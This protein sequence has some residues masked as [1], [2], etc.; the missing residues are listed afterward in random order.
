MTQG[1]KIVLDESPEI[2]VNHT[3]PLPTID[4]VHEHVHDGAFWS[5]ANNYGAT[6]STH[7]WHIRTANTTTQ[8]HLTAYVS[9]DTPGTVSLYK[10]PATHSITAAAT[11][12]NLAPVNHN[13]SDTTHTTTLQVFGGTAYDSSLTSTN[14]LESAY[15]GASVNP[16]FTFGGNAAS[17][18]EWILAQNSNYTLKWICAA[19]GTANVNISWYTVG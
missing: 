5:V 6:A 3:N 15:I 12:T 13:L 11:G 7:Y 17:R 19:T 2:T 4:I 1:Y 8:N 18:N 14:L 10:S 16:A 9:A